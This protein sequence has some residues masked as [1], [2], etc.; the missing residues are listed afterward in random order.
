MP[1]SEYPLKGDAIIS[2][3][4]RQ[5]PNSAKSVVRFHL[6]WPPPSAVDGAH[7]HAVESR[8][9]TFK[10]PGERKPSKHRDTRF[11]QDQTNVLFGIRRRRH[12]KVPH[13][14]SQPLDQ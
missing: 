6:C 5:I 7:I 12:A 10:I 14:S 3:N 9:V 8:K 4:N 13:S 2:N 1:I 11:V